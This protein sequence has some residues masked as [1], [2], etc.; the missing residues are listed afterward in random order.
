M[1]IQRTSV[2]TGSILAALLTLGATADAQDQ[3]AQSP[4]GQTQSPQAP[5]APTPPASA[6]ASAPPPPQAQAD[7]GAIR[8][9][10][11]VA[12]PNLPQITVTAPHAKPAR[13]LPAV[14]RRTVPPVSPAEAL[15]AKNNGF[16]QARSNLYTTDRHDIRHD[17]P[18]HH[19]GVA[20]R[21]QQPGRERAAA[22]ARRVAGF[23]G[24]RPAPCPQRSRQ[25]AIPHQRRH[26]ARRRHRLRQ[27]SRYR[28]DRHYLARHRRAAGR[29][30]HAHGR[31]RSTSPPAT[32]FSTI[33]AASVYYG[34]SRGTIEP[35]FEYGGTFGGNC[36]IERGVARNG[37]AVILARLLS[38]ACNISSP[39]A[40]CRPRRASKIRCRRSTPSTI[41]RSR[42]EASPICRPSST[43]IRA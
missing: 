11:A 14:P 26:A 29:I 13:Q 2:V 22:G 28:P 43:P 39:A 8:P 31:P 32:T 37:E 7:A 35:S 12:T 23:R 18:R 42:K 19:R 4:A 25:C 36:P 38:A 30:R 41:S 16:D 15:N 6:I 17:E 34:G 20:A 27:R 1:S 33:P 40:I 9:Q 10:A 5:S 3:P 24:E 21:H